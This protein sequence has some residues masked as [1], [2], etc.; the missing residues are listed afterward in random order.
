MDNFNTLWNRLLNRA[1]SIGNILAQ[2]LVNDS[3]HTLQAQGEWSWRRRSFNFAPKNQYITGTVTTN[4]GAGNPTLLTGTGTVWTTD[5][6]GQQIRVGGLMFPF[7][8]IT[9]WISPTQILIDSAWAGPDVVDQSYQIL[10]AY[11][12]VPSD[13]GYWYLA[14]SIKDGYRIY[15]TI[16]EA[17][18]G[19]LDPQ[20]GN[21]GQTYAFAFRDYVTQFGGVV[22]PIIPVAATGATPIST[23]S[24]GFSYVADATYILQIVGGGASGTATFQWMRS[25]QSS[26]TGPVLTS[27]SAITLV[28]GVQVYF[29]IGTYVANDL[30]VINCQ[31]LITEGVPRYEAWPAPTFD[32]Y[33]YPTIYIAK[34]YDLT[35]AA[36]SLPPFVANRGEIL[37]EMALEKCATFPGTIEQP[38]PYFDLRL[39][40]VHREKVFDMMIDFRNNDQ[41]VGVENVQYQNFSY[42]GPFAGPY[43][44]WYDGSYQQR[45][46]PSF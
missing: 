18:L 28:D 29:P 9:G 11:F 1:P 16:T 2:Q 8:T 37:L 41:E 20:R 21:Q 3:W 38:N 42:A 43:G 40:Q 13:F 30:F 45:H 44:V 32:G 25:G 5:M 39:A 31:S 17:E 26:F 22:G 12:A 14:I 24:T 19:L 35:P 23:T 36:P 27:T 10:T 46:A 34:E 7:Y 33:L 6:I 15:T 4:S